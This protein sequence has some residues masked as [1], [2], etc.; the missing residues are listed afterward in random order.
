M[1]FSRKTI[2]RAVD[3]L[4]IGNAEIT[5]LELEFALEAPGYTVQDRANA[6]ARL[7]IE[8]PHRVYDGENTVE[9]IVRRAVGALI[10]RVKRANLRGRHEEEAK[11][12]TQPI[13][14]ALRKDGFTVGEDGQLQSM[15][16]GI[17]D[18]PAADDET[19]TLLDQHGLQ[20]SKG[21]L[22]QALSCHSRGDWA[23]ANGQIRTF[24]EAMLDEIALKLDPTSVQLATSENRRQRLAALSPP[25]LQPDLN[26]WDSTG[27][28]FVNGLLKRLHANG[29]H[30]GL[31][32]EEDSTFRLQ[33]VLLCARLF[34]RR[35]SQFV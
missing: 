24:V 13:W 12:L 30:P 23:A 16:P 9:A 8:D 21:H 3:V 34:L 29:S 2:M 17:V 32:D 20:T 15:M 19:H 18:I 26:E 11:I 25:F 7:L 10:S 28:N 35:F 33:L 6:I 31:S 5:A 4:A 14:N 1:P 27:K 22:D